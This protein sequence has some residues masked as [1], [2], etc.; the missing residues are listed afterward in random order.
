MSEGV[1]RLEDKNKNKILIKL[2]YKKYAHKNTF[3]LILFSSFLPNT[4]LVNSTLLYR[5]KGLES[6][7]N[8]F[9]SHL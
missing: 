8:S 3:F 4:L 2:V 1:F 9:S 6:R 5:E 7:W